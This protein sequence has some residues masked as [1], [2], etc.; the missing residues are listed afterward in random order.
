MPYVYAAFFCGCAFPTVNFF[1]GYAQQSQSLIQSLAATKLTKWAQ[2]FLLR[3]TGK[4]Q[5]F[6][7]SGGTAANRGKLA[8][9]EFQRNI[10][11]PSKSRCAFAPLHPE[12]LYFFPLRHLFIDVIAI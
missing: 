2:P 10:A 5:P 3:L 4:A 8:V 7:T 1:R 9:K 6:R 12:L 11:N